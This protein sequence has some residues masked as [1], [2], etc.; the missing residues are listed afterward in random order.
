M[1]GLADKVAIVVGG[2]SGIG[3]ASARALGAAGAAL[4]LAGRDINR[5][6]AVADQ[7]TATGVRCRFVPADV[8]AVEAIGSVVQTAVE[9]FGHVDILV[10][11]AGHTRPVSFFDICEMDW[12][13]LLGVNARAVLFAMQAAAAQ[14]RATGGGRIINIASVGGL[15]YGRSSNV[16]YAAAKGAVIAMTKVAAFQLARYG[17]TV[18]AIC[19]GYTDTP[20]YAAMLDE[21][22]AVS[23]RDREALL[24]EVVGRIPL[25]KVNRAADVAAAVVFLA[26]AGGD[27]ITGH[28]LVV[29]GGLMVGG[30]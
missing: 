11:S 30:L 4:I 24:R 12:E 19:P 6:E 14:M 26:S 5:G 8:R 18:N 15:G 25:R 1:E 3:E 27:Q 10:N 23:S 28:T 2:S 16:A 29:D 21:I 17:I 13:E 7:L 22:A 9:M 20:M